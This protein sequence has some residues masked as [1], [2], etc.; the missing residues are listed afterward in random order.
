MLLW[1]MDQMRE[2]QL[3]WARE[4]YWQEGQARGAIRT[5]KAMGLDFADA[6]QH[7]QALLPELPQADAERLVRYYWRDD[8]DGT[9]A[10][11]RIDDKIKHRITMA[12]YRTQYNGACCEQLEESYL[13][14]AVYALAETIN[15]C[16]PLLDE[17]YLQRAADRLEL[18]LENLKKRLDAVMK[19]FF[20]E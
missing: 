16:G 19:E 13:K 20:S 14:G 2:L 7:L 10:T 15:R 9:A 1:T 3:Q 12:I 8:I 11:E 5:C 4:L 18:P 6:L 17:D